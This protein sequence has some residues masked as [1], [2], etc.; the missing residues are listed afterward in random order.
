MPT[1]QRGFF[2]EKNA[3]LN[4]FAH[5]KALTPFKLK[6]LLEYFDNDPGIAWNSYK[7]WPHGLISPKAM[8]KAAEVI[9]NVDI[10]FCWEKVLLK[11][12]KTTSIYDSDYPYFLKQI[13]DPPLL[14]YYYGQLPK[15]RQHLITVVGSRKISSY[16]KDALEYLLKPLTQAGVGIISGLA[17]GTDAE[18]HRL[19]LAQNV[20][21]LGVLASG[22]NRI[23]PVSNINLARNIYKAGGAV[24][25]EF[26]PGINAA[27]HHFQQRNRILAGLSPTTLIIEAANKSG[28]LITAKYAVDSNRNI[29][30]VPVSIFSQVSKGCNSLL[31][32]GAQLI[33]KPEELLELYNLSYTDINKNVSLNKE[34]AL[35]VD[36]L[37]NEPCHFDTL[38]EKSLLQSNSLLT[39]LTT[40]ELKGI[41]CNVP[42][43]GYSL[44]HSS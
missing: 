25:S 27:K 34:E 12:I 38:H 6:K 5:I 8:N 26:P 36:L 33:S 2:M 22:V 14:L 39:L 24:I 20:Y 1:P 28:T 19:A 3:W 4:G 18:A 29:A 9:K 7:N 44:K 13:P 40:L 15:A 23:T 37:G 35:I 16:G 31:A 11:K 30:A 10:A 41:V 32:Q 17:F 42:G 43:L 21:T